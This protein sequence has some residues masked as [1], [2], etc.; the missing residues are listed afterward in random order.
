MM[1]SELWVWW[2]PGESEEGLRGFYSAQEWAKFV[3]GERGPFR[4]R[5]T[6]PGYPDM[7]QMERR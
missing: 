5:L 7:P 4:R 1:E 6:K 2:S 3:R